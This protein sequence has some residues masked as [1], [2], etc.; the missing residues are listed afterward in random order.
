MTEETLR[1]L[2]LFVPPLRGLGRVGLFGG[3]FNPPHLAHV[4]AALA[5]YGT[6]ELDH[7]WVLPTASHAF[8]KDLAP[9]PDRV[10]MAHLAFRH[11][12]GGVAVLDLEERLPKPSFTV[13]LLRA[14]HRL[15][16]GIKPVWIAG[17]DFL[18]DLPRW[19]EP[20][21][22]VRLA[23]IVVL[24]RQGHPPPGEGAAVTTVVDDDAPPPRAGVTLSPLTF[25][26]PRLSSTDVRDRLRT[27][28][29]ARGLV[30]H[31]VLAYV[32]RRGLYR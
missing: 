11:F 26:L 23:R 19:R 32:E 14:L 28:Q 18:A 29:G 3:S 25:D 17:S 30:D 12:A 2:D 31:E 15:R 1:A 8:G 21:E 7:L 22:V 9:F 27:G 10:R 6:E 5:V 16:P 24:L 13:N 4:L 20:D